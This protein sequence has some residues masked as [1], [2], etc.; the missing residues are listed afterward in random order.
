MAN[1]NRPEKGR[2]FL[3]QHSNQVTPASWVTVAGLRS[4]SITI[5]GEEVNVSS[6]DSDGWRELLEAGGERSVNISAAGVFKDSAVEAL[7]RTAALNQTIE[8]FR[9]LYDNGDSWI[10]DFQITS[11]EH[12]GENNGAVM[13]TMSLSSHGPVTFTDV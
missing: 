4:T 7:V 12:A 5:N 9:I 8:M 6:K 13:Y 2:N 3:L 11:L 10:G 1:A